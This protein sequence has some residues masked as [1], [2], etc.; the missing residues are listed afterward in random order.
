MVIVIAFSQC[1]VSSESPLRILALRTDRDEG[2]EHYALIHVLITLVQHLLAEN[3]LKGTAS[4]DQGRF[5]QPEMPFH[6]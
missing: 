2:M 1:W 6:M 3:G 5:K 4:E